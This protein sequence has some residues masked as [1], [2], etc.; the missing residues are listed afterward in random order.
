MREVSIYIATSIK[1]RWERDGYIGY[2]LEYYPPGKDLPEIRR[3]IEPVGHMNTN[4][5]ELEA[6][7]RA[8]SRMREKCVLSI[9]TESEYLYNGFAGREDVV[10]WIENGWITA[11]GSEVKKRDKWMAL[12]RA[13][14]G[15]ECVFY[16]KQPNAYIDSLKK[17][18]QKKE[19]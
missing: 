11:R 15:N 9:Y 17:E 12:I 6:L 13:K 18:M 5:A 10:H 16:L 3:E 19:R 8:F 7:I 14:Q 2:C 4:R 1:G